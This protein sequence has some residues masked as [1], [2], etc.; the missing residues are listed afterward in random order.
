MPASP[1]AIAP[2]A[3]TPVVPAPTTP[4]DTPITPPAAYKSDSTINYE[5]GF[6]GTFLDRKLSLELVGFYV[7]WSDIQVA[8]NVARNV[9][10]PGQLGFPVAINGGKGVS[11]GFE[12]NIS[13]KPL[14][15]LTIGWSGAHVDATLKNAIPIINAPADVQLPYSPRWSHSATA[16]YDLPL[17]DTLSANLGVIY[18][19]VGARYSTFSS[20]PSQSHQF[21]PSYDTWGVSAGVTLGGFSV[22]AYG[23]NLDNSRGVTTYSNGRITPGGPFP[24]LAGLIRPREIGL[25]VTGR[26]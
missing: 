2:A 14:T 18:S 6:K 17:S 19:F 5:V 3:P 7:D 13:A 16:G 20:T 10:T 4:L 22:Q 21:I 15:G 23:K 24:G 1:R 8:G 26:F 9:G 11:K 12:W 25:R